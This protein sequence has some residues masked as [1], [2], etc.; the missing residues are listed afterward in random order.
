MK[1]EIIRDLIPLYDENL[2]SA[3]S[4]ALV[5]EHI[6]TCA[7]CKGLLEKL[8]KTDIPKFDPNGIKPFLKINRKL[9]A[10]TATLIAL[11]SVLLAVLIPIGYLTVNQIF[12]FKGGTDFEDILAKKGL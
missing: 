3:E 12:H 5:E 1:C 7:A 11:G 4:A 10:R 8:P 9:R 2:C 6:Q